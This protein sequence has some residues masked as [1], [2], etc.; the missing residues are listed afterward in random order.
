MGNKQYKYPRAKGRVATMCLDTMQTEAWRSLNATA[1][2]IYPWL[3][4]E[5]RGSN[6]NNNGQLSIS[7][8]QLCEA[9]GIAKPDTI[10]KG[11]KDL[12]AKGFVAVRENAQLGVEGQGRSFEFEITEIAMPG[13]DASGKPFQPRKLFNEWRSERDFEVVSAQANN[14]NGATEKNKTPSQ[15][16][17]SPIPKIG[18]LSEGPIPKI[19]K[20]HPKNRDDMAILEGKASQKS[21]YPTPTISKGEQ[22]D[23]ARPPK[24]SAQ[25]VTS[26]DLPTR[27]DTSFLANSLQQMD[28]TSRPVV[29]RYECDRPESEILASL[30]K[31][32]GPDGWRKISVRTDLQDN[33]PSMSDLTKRSAAE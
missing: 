28:S 29:R 16:L 13:K 22:T 26:K 25:S 33:Q 3:K 24:A 4:L 6:Q 18:M 7:Y 23:A 2:I 20:P 19:G 9:T 10:A 12:Q 31:K 21:G 30:T 14:P 17:G 1:Q 8:R 5:W 27:F 11:F 15:K 32:L